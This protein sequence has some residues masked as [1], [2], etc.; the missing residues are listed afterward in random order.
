MQETRIGGIVRYEDCRI[1]VICTDERD[2]PMEG[3]DHSENF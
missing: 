3:N 1:A 2:M